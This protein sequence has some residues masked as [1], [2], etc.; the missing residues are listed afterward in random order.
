MQQGRKLLF[1]SYLAGF[2]SALL[3]FFLL[4][5]G[6]VYLLTSQGITITLDSGKIAQLVRVQVVSEAQRSLP[7]LIDDAKAEIP[8]I[9]EAQM[10]EQIVSD[11]MEIAGFVFRV[12]EELLGQ[13][14]QSIQSNVEKAATEILSGID[15]VLVAEDIG[16]N[17][18]L[19]VRQTLVRELHG[20]LYQVLAYGRIPLNIRIKVVN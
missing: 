20:D 16:E 18:Y 17:V 12:P 13:L 4:L 5:G 14:R 8:G 7:R 3:L 2:A 9:V 19:L 15:T 6:A 10:R 1:S 11:R